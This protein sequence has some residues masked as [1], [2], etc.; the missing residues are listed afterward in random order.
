MRYVGQIDDKRRGKRRKGRGKTGK[1]R[2]EK[3][4]KRM[5]KNQEVDGSYVN[6]GSKRRRGGR[7][8][9]RRREE[10]NTDK[11]SKHT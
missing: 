6:L 9:E 2:K 1:E 8:E 3:N 5:D 11:S 10:I 4:G 7:G